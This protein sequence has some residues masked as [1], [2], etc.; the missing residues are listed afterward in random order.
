MFGCQTGMKMALRLLITRL[1]GQV[2]RPLKLRGFPSG[3]SVFLQ[4]L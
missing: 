1:V 3:M 2:Y 4:A